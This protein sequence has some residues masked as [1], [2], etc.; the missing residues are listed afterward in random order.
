MQ[1]NKSILHSM[2]EW[3]IFANAFITV[4]LYTY[5]ESAHR[6]MCFKCRSDSIRLTHIALGKTKF[7]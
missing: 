3:Y 4:V 1:F 2:H 5:V 7:A 6:D